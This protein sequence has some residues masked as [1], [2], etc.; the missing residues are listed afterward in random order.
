MNCTNCQSALPDLLLDPTSPAARAAET[1]LSECVACRAELESLQ[2]TFQM[3]DVWEAPEPSPWF[4]SRLAARLREEEAKAPASWLERL[5]DS[6][7]FSTGRHLRPALAGAFGLLLLLGGGA[8][9][10]TS[11]G[12]L[13]HSNPQVSAAVQDLQIL[14]RNDQAFQTMDQLLQGDDAQGDDNSAGTPS[15]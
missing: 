7:R 2:E 15:S 8:A 12:L 13:H 4:D 5:A 14:D 1:H 6:F 9:V 11:T 10:T 3:L